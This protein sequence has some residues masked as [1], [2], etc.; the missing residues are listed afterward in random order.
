MWFLPTRNR[1]QECREL[2]AA[3]EALEPMPF[4]AVMIDDDPAKYADVKWPP[5]WD[6][7]VAPEHLEMTRANNMLLEMYPSHKCY[8][9]FGDHFRP[10]TPMFRDLE[11][12]AGDWF[13]A[14]PEDPS[15]HGGICGA[16]TFGGK[17]IR[18]LGWINLPTTV[19]IATELPF[20]WLWH[21]L[22]IVRI[23]RHHEFTRTRPNGM[24]HRPPRNY[25][26]QDYYAADAAAARK[27]R[28]EEAP[29]V[30]RRIREGMREDGYDFLSNGIIH[31]KHGCTPLN[32]QW[33]ISVKPRKG[34]VG[35]GTLGSIPWG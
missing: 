17:L 11:R 16:P 27:W 32:G 1:P 3:F 35:D 26:G 7:H 5:Y 22:G 13:I 31:S 34:G 9:W 8:G 4:V 21:T 15:G 19:H 29:G 10:R 30:I 24:D 20:Q 2:V 6:V 12:A 23:V 18:A 28:L 33:Q 14:W 25:R